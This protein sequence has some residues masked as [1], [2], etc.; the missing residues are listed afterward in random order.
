[1]SDSDVTCPFCK[2][3]GYD[4]IGLKDH[5]E[6]NCKAYADTL[7]I[8]EERQLRKSNFTGVIEMENN[9]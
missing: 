1:M 2:M 7:S 3:V 5:L 6:N 8:E 9:G 4:L